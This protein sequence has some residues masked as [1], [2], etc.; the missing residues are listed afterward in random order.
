MARTRVGWIVCEQRTRRVTR[1]AVPC[2]VRGLVTAE[3]CL[4]CHLMVTW[5]GERGSS[6]W[7]ETAVGLPQRLIESTTGTGPTWTASK[8]VRERSPR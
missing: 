4:D 5:S 1:G 7:C 8:S 3:A 6:G 2:P